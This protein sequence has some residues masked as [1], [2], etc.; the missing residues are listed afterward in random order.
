METQVCK[1]SIR[2]GLAMLIAW[3]FFHHPS[4]TTTFFLGTYWISTLYQA[5]WWCWNT[6]KI[7]I[8][9]FPSGTSRIASN[10]S[11]VS[12]LS[13]P[14]G[15]LLIAVSL[16]MDNSQPMALSV[17]SPSSILSAPALWHFFLTA[18]SISCHCFRLPVL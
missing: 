1:T 10:K 7:Q 18:H 15:S 4:S 17:F 11:S 14:V 3:A 13:Y 16:F 8:S 9:Q 12:Y 2:N 6:E 5:V